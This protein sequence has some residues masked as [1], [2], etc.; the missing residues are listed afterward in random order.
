MALVASVSAAVSVSVYCIFL[1]LGVLGVHSSSLPASLDLHVPSLSGDSFLHIGLDFGLKFQ[2][3][4]SLSY[5]NW[6]SV[7]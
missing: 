6:L 2:V 7:S 3:P 1:V 4:T 5:W